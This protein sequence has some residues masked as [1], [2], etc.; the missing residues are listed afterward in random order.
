MF[1]FHKRCVLW[2]NSPW[3]HH[4]CS[5]PCSPPFRVADSAIVSFPDLP[6]GPVVVWC[7]EWQGSLTMPNL[8]PANV[9]E[10]TK[11]MVQLWNLSCILWPPTT[12]VT[13]GLPV[14]PRSNK[15]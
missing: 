7:Y 12:C 11:S 13:L 6:Q 15:F 10:C 1:L 2:A 14:K 5:S 8:M 4:I 3:R 9:W